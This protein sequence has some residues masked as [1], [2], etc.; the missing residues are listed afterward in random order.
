MIKVGSIVSIV[1]TDDL[2]GSGLSELKDRTGM[3]IEDL[4]GKR[5]SN[6]GY[7]VRLV[8]QEFLGEKE[9]FIPEKSVVE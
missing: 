9:W 8:G 3:V 4:C 7:W 1:D 5:T 2:R 6:R